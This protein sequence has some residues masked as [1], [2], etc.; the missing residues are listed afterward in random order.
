M[1]KLLLFIFVLT[2]LSG[3]KKKEDDP[4]NKVKTYIKIAWSEPIAG[5]EISTSNEIKVGLEYQINPYDIKGY[6]PVRVNVLIRC[7]TAYGD[8]QF[9]T[10]TYGGIL[11]EAP[12]YGSMDYLVDLDDY[13]SLSIYHPVEL[14]FAFYQNTNGPTDYFYTSDGIVF[15]N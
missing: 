11:V 6:G 3:C 4:A 9:M 8:S 14:K 13:K 15:K 12:F 2:I 5:K 1:K 10:K 7:I